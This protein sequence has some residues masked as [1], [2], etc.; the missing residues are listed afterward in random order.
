MIDTNKNTDSTIF[1]D[2]ISAKECTDTGMALVL[3]CLLAALFTGTRTW[4]TAAVALLLV[5]MVVPRV[6]FLP[7]K[8]WLGFSGLLGTVVS[9]I[10]LTVIFFLVQTPIALLRRAAGHD[11]MQLKQWKKGDGSVFQTRNHLYHPEEI[12]RPY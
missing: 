4:L 7:A 3:I 2:R 8:V 5:N 6:Y 11:P 12:E 1:P 10:L 9:K